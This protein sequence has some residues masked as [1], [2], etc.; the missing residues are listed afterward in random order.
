VAPAVRKRKFSCCRAPAVGGPMATLRAIRSS[1]S[2]HHR[3]RHAMP[4]SRDGATQRA[5]SRAVVLRAY[6]ACCAACC[7]DD[8][9]DGDDGGDEGGGG[10]RSALLSRSSVPSSTC[11]P[12]SHAIEAPWLVNSGHGA[13]L[14]HHNERRSRR[15]LRCHSL[16]G[17]PSPALAASSGSSRPPPPP[18]THRRGAPT[19]GVL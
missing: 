7:D 8:D 15:R 3:R 11:T 16:R 9:G 2:H 5:R 18:H 17:T 1:S 19:G 4:C 6:R 14:R 12:V 13:S 10:T